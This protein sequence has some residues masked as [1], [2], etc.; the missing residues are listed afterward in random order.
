MS[1]DVDI[2]AERRRRAQVVTRKWARVRDFLTALPDPTGTIAEL[3]AAIERLGEA[4]W[5]D[6][7]VQDRA[8]R[9]LPQVYR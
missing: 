5:T 1:G 2:H 9:V 4:V 8:A 3:D 6:E 7:P